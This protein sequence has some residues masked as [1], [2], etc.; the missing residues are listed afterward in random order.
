MIFEVMHS[1]QACS[2]SNAIFHTVIQQ[3]TRL[4]LTVSSGHCATAE[5]VVFNWLVF[6]VRCRLVEIL[7]S[8]WK[9]QLICVLST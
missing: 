4:R 2:V 1:L 8:L 9:S 3:L 5:P 6:C 7:R